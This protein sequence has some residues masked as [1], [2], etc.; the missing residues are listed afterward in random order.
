M[1]HARRICEQVLGRVMSQVTTRV[2]T[3]AGLRFSEQCGPVVRHQIWR[4]KQRD[5]SNYCVQ[6]WLSIVNQAE[7]DI[8]ESD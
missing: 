5:N 7:E 2:F 3:P 6:A 1:I 8:D 4:R